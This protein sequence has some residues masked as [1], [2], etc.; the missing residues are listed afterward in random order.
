MKLRCSL[1]AILALS[2]LQASEDLGTLNV[3]SST[4]DIKTNLSTESSSIA[5]IDEETIDIVGSKNITDILRTVP[6]MTNVARAGETVQFRFRGVGAQQYMGE[7]PGVAIVIDGVPVMSIS[8]GVRLNLDDIKS[9]KV[10]KGSAS[11]LYGDTALSGAV[12]ITTKKMNTK[13]ESSI[14]TEFGSYGFQNYK[15]STTQN[16]ENFSFNL[17][18]SYRSTDGYWT[19]SE[20]WTKSV[21]GKFSYYLDDSSD[22]TFG[23]DITDKYDQGGARSVVAG[24]TAAKENPKGEADTGYN[25]DSGIDLDKYYLSYNKEFDNSSLQ[26][27]TYKYNDL[28][29]LISNPQDTDNDTSTKNI[30]VNESH[31]DLTQKGIKLEYTTTGDTMASL[32]GIE[33]GQKEY[34]N[35]DETLANY[36]EYNTYSRQDENYYEGET[37]LTNSQDDTKALYGELK[38]NI[39]PKFTTTVNVRYDIQDKEYTT[40]SHDFNGTVWSDTID[41]NSESFRNTAYKLGTNYTVSKSLNIF[42]NIATGYETPDVT[43]L[44]ETPSLKNQ[45]SITYEVGSRGQMANNFTYET[46]IYQIDNKDILGPEEGT[47]GFGSPMA[48]IGDSRHRGLE[49]SLKS[50]PEK[51][52]SYSLAYTYLN[53]KYTSHLPHTISFQDKTSHT[54]DIVG[55]DIPRVSKHTVDLFLNYKATKKLKIITEIYAKSSYW[56]DEMNMIKMDG[57]EVLNLQARYNTKIS[58]NTLEF[59]VKVDNVFDKQFYRAAYLHRDK[60]GDLGIDREDLSLTVDPGRVYY[61]GVK[62]IF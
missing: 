40:D 46:S 48:N 25:K 58:N 56:A 37:S 10:I 24:E 53:A 41:S 7:K 44:A 49:V 59:F 23:A 51:T 4:I 13:S 6:G 9:V 14:S 60:R 17:N 61:A 19:D 55:N 62:Y 29:E 1:V 3:N 18:G 57:Y 8:G 50:D 34:E 47:Y 54:Y 5:I 32:F 15:A 11:Y 52:F 45:T 38:Y 30:Y 27:T 28:Y 20:M 42:T 33:V 16:M 39:T 12:I 36:S 31:D 2:T 26:I 22:L 21:N 35:T 43:D